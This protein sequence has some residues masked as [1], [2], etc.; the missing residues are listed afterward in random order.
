[1]GKSLKLTLILIGIV[2]GIFFIVPLVLSSQVEVEATKVI[3][4]PRAQVFEQISNLKNRAHWT[5]FEKTPNM[6]DSL[7][8][9]ETGI[10]SKYYW[11][12][13]DTIKRVLSITQMKVPDFVQMELWFPNN[14]G[15]TEKWTLTG[16]S[17]NTYV[18]WHFTVL[19]LKY[20]FG[21][22]LGLVLDNSL[23]NVLKEGLNKL[24]DACIKGNTKKKESNQPI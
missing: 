16:D 15:A 1:M 19:N 14:H 20:P 18:S 23:G 5:P 8:V 7:S 21:K 9:P 24:N 3:K 2:L 10:G 13:G 6:R 11:K 12:S 17:T 22:W 4:A